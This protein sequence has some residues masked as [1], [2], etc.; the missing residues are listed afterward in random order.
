MSTSLEARGSQAIAAG[1]RREVLRGALR[2]GQRLPSLQDLAR[3]HG[4][5][6]ITVRRALRRLE[7]EGLL[8]VEHGVGA[9]V[10][11]WTR[12]MELLA[13][14]GFRLGE[15]PSERA[16]ET[17]VLDRGPRVN[18]DA[19]AALAADLQR[20]LPALTRLRLIDGT[21]LVLQRSYLPPELHEVVQEYREDDSLYAVLRSRSGRAPV[22]AEEDVR[23]VLLDEDRAALLGVEAGGPGWFAFRVTRDQ[24]GESLLVDEAWMSGFRV[25]LRFRRTPSG[26]AAEFVPAG[27]ETR[28]EEEG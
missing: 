26:A 10:A 8:R 5:T 18:C 14:P 25:H 9:F 28:G 20:A 23:A 2:P 6:P 4:A 21:P 19:A 13:L 16:L 1:L 22:S 11:D 24:F 17:R 27:K 7:E 12:G 15:G 3:R